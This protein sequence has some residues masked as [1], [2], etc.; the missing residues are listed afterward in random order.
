M[1][2]FKANHITPGRALELVQTA[3]KEGEEDGRTKVLM[4]LGVFLHQLHKEMEAQTDNRCTHSL[5]DLSCPICILS[6]I[7]NEV[8]FRLASLIH[9]LEDKSMVSWKDR[10]EEWR[11]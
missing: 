10:I 6:D 1:I 9:K 5:R 11:K 4:E 3:R 7:G 8:H 2:C